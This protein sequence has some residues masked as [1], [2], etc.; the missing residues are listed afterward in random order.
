MQ[1]KQ[2]QLL[3]LPLAGLKNGESVTKKAI[4]SQV[5]IGVYLRTE[6][7]SVAPEDKKSPVYMLEVT[8]F[9]ATV[10]RDGASVFNT[11][12]TGN[13]FNEKTKLF[14]SSMEPGDIV[15]FSGIKAIRQDGDSKTS[16]EEM[17]LK[18]LLYVINKKST[19]ICR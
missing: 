19:S 17:D 8:S 12:N 9:K 4:T 6:H 5:G 13:L 14:F 11:D 10:I 1:K 15:L 2:P 3:W 16:M 7:L 18:P